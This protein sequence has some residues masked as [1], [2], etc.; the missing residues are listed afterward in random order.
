MINIAINGFGRIGRMFLRSAWEQESI[1]IV[2]VNDLTSTE[3]LAALLKRDSVHG[4]FNYDVS[5]KDSSITI[6]GQEIPVYREK[7][8]KDLPWHKHDVDV[9]IESTGFFRTKDKASMHLDAGAD[10]V[11]ISA[12]AKG[13]KDVRTVVLGVNED[14]YN[15]ERIV[16]NA[17]CT[18]NCLSPLAKVL[19]DNY[20]VERG[21]MTTTHSYTGSQ[22]LIDGPHKDLR[23]ARAAA[24]NLVPTTTG[25]AVA[26][27]KVLPELKGKLD[28]F[29]IRTPTP[30]GSITD[31]TVQTRQ[32]VSVKQVNDLFRNVAEHHLKGIV[33]YSEE[34][35]VS[36][37]IV[38]N[39]H[40]VIFDAEQT[41]VIDGNL[42][43]VVGWY[44]N[45]WGYSS[46]LVDLAI[47]IS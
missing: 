31:L 5:Y 17:S 8:P 43:K 29:A 39:P 26:V 10:K 13:D 42:V 24:V 32:N 40:S 4:E 19:H 11:V 18:T 23:R 9:V 15:N 46:R 41:R 6:D 30:D 27:G 22:N 25:A 2:A 16:S 14:E 21:F 36:S 37:D 45:E 34:P 33:E 38:G 20:G 35:L 7:S 28:G 3:T 1:N 12:P 47:Y 44:D